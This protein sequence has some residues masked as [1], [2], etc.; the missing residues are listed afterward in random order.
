MCRCHQLDTAF[1]SCSGQEGRGE[2]SAEERAAASG[3]DVRSPAFNS[4]ARPFWGPLLSFWVA[5]EFIERVSNICRVCGQVHSKQKA[6]TAK[7]G[8][9][10]K[11][12]GKGRGSCAGG[13]KR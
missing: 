7:K 8:R 9:K 11:G 10:G 4:T 5:R 2:V 12:G 6:K 13:S 3:A 1:V